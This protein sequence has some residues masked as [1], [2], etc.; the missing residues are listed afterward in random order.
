MGLP[1]GSDGSCRALHI[2]H[3]GRQSAWRWPR[4][5][6]VRG[7][8]F[9]QFLSDPACH[10]I[11]TA[12]EFS[13][14]QA[15]DDSLLRRNCSPG[16]CPPDGVSPT[17]L[18]IHTPSLPFLYLLRQ[19]SACVANAGLGPHSRPSGPC[20]RH[21][22]G[23]TSDLFVPQLFPLLLETVERPHP[24]VGHRLGKVEVLPASGVPGNFCTS[25]D[26]TNWY[27]TS[28]E[29]HE[30]RSIQ[31]CARKRRVWDMP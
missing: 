4:S 2:H 20:S 29:W 5:L 18:S 26:E 22:L 27:E 10:R 15:N 19:H 9:H 21:R 24:P 17:N 1:D 25:G 14:S 31:L 30:G 7:N 16:V 6:H 3:D 13:R 28:L 8:P 12:Q 23:Y 11:F